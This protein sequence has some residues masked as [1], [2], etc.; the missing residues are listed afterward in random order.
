MLALWVQVQTLISVTCP[1]ESK[2]LNDTFISKMLI[3][4]SESDGGNHF[5]VRRSFC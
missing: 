4:N 1:Y 3:E 2:M 5:L